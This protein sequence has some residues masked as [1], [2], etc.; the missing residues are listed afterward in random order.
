MSYL[1]RLDKNIDPELAKSWLD[2]AWYEELGREFE[3]K[4]E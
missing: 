1:E 2:L 3:V 4:G